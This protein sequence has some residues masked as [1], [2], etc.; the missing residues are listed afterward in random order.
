MTRDD[1]VEFITNRLGQTDQT[2]LDLCASFVRARYRMIYDAELWRDSQRVTSATVLANTSTVAFPDDVERIISIRCAGDHFLDPIDST[3]LVESDP[4]IFERTGTPLFFEDY[5]DPSD[6]TRKLR[7]FPH[8][9]MDTALLVVGKR[10]FPDLEDGDDTPV[11]RNCENAIIAYATGDFLERQRQYGKAEQKFQEA[12]AHLDGMRQLEAKQADQ[13]RMVKGLGTGGNTLGGLADEVAARIGDYAP[14]TYISIKQFLRREYQ[15]IWDS[16]LWRQALVRGASTVTGG[17]APLPDGFERVI[18]VRYSDTAVLPID[19]ALQFEVDALAFEASGVPAGY[20]ESVAGDGTM[21]I[22]LHPS[23][24]DSSAVL[25]LG[26]LACPVLAADTDVAKLRNVGN[27]LICFASAD[28]MMRNPAMAAGAADMRAQGTAH[29]GIMQSAEVEQSLKQRQTRTITVAGN[30]L[31]EMTDAA[32]ARCGVYDIENIILVREFLRRQYLALYDSRPWKESLVMARV[33]TDGQTVIL[34][35]YMDRVI[36]VRGDR[37]LTMSTVDLVHIYLTCPALFDKQTGGPCLFSI[38]TSVATAALPLAATM[39]LVSSD[40]A[41]KCAVF[42]R[43]DS[44]GLDL[45]ETVT[46]NG[47]TAVSTVNTYDTPLTLAKPITKGNLTVRSGLPAVTLLVLPAAERERKH[48]RL[49]LHPGTETM[50]QDYLVLGKRHIHPLVRDEDTPLIRDAANALIHA[51][52][53]DLAARMGKMDM[54]NDFRT[55]A[56][57]AVKTL[58]DLETHQGAQMTQIVP[59]MEPTYYGNDYW[60]GYWR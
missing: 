50:G 5:T 24:P 56:G 42:I 47:T 55:Q 44:N 1:F 29:V 43:G 14:A 45:S 54:A 3:Y 25:V 7:V 26:K 28:M 20:T 35:E 9:T 53:G 13:M 38:L 32:L 49:W 22:E 23:P 46:L 40:A 52:A 51:A 57:A 2:S 33:R 36:A 31:A 15:M 19:M 10:P 60:D 41:D 37:N 8:P 21:R 48:V 34:P 6:Q 16:Y 27:A 18:S 39:S 12:A 30:S 59:Y 17:I 11:L 58:V 4:T